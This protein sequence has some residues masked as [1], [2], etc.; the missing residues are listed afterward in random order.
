MFNV[1]SFYKFKKI[2]NL[3]K[4]KNN[5]QHEVLNNNVR[6]TIIISKEGI[7]GTISGKNK[8][9]FN[10]KKINTRYFSL[11][12]YNTLIN[13]AIKKNMISEDEKTILFKWQEN[14]LG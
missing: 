1:F 8:D 5:L 3:K 10:I 12:D 9:L 14:H 11:C 13:V 2:T 6:G 4:I 7:N